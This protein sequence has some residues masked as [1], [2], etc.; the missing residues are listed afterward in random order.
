MDWHELFFMLML[1]G[2]SDEEIAEGY[3]TTP[4]RVHTLIVLDA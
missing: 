1:A 2:W 4:E 3:G